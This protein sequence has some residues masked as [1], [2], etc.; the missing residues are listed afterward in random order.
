M[1]PLGAQHLD[2]WLN[3]VAQWHSDLQSKAT[4][5][6]EFERGLLE[7][8][9]WIRPLYV[10]KPGHECQVNALN[11]LNETLE[12]LGRLIEAYRPILWS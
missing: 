8:L 6:A 12:R 11:E 7:T 2:A 9:N 10:P 4:E 3:S 1:S 5:L